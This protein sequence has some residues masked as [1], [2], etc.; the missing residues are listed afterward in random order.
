MLLGVISVL[1]IFILVPSIYASTKDVYI[2]DVVVEKK[3]GST[4]VTTNPSY[5]GMNIKLAL[6]FYGINDSIRYKVTVDNPSDED[7]IISDKGTITD[8]SNDYIKYEFGWEDTD[9]VV[10][11]NT[12]KDF[13]IDV[14][15]VKEVP[16]SGFDESGKFIEDRVITVKL[17]DE[18]NDNTDIPTVPD[19]QPSDD[20]QD[21]NE[22]NKDNQVDLVPTP[23]KTGD[24]II[25]YV[26][27]L[28]VALLGLIIL[29]I[30]ILRNRGLDLKNIFKKNINK[31]S[32][33]LFIIVVLLIVGVIGYTLGLEQVEITM[34]SRVEIEQT[35]LAMSCNADSYSEDF[36]IDW[37]KYVDYSKYPDGYT[38]SLITAKTKNM[39]DTYTNEDGVVYKL[40]NTYDV[41]DK[42]NDQVILGVY[43]ND[44]GEVLLIIG[45][46]NGVL[47]PIDSSYLFASG[48]IGRHYVES[49]SNSDFSNKMQ[50][51]NDID[52][53]KNFYEHLGNI[54]SNIMESVNYLGLENLKVDDSINM[55]GMFANN[56]YGPYKNIDYRLYTIKGL[57]NWDTSNV[58]SMNGMFAST[59]YFAT[60]IDFDLSNFDTSNVVDMGYI[61]D[62]TGKRVM[63]L[64]IGNIS[65]WDVSNV[66]SMY[67]MFNK[68]GISAGSLEMN[69]TDWN[70]SK[71]VDMGYMFY[72]C[73]FSSIGDISNWD[74]SNVK[75]MN[76]M[77]AGVDYDP[78]VF[79]LDLRNWDVS[80]VV[81]MHGMFE[82]FSG[83][84]SNIGISNWD[85][86]NVTSMDGM[87]W[88]SSMSISSI[89][90]DLSNWDVSNVVSMHG[91]FWQTGI[92]SETL[93]LNLSNWNTSKVTDMSD[94]FYLTG[95]SSKIFELNVSNWDTS[96][97]EN[98]N[99]MFY[100]TGENAL[101][102]EVDLSNWDT[103]KV[104]DMGR[105]F[106]DIGKNS[107]NP[108]LKLNNFT[109][110]NVSNFNF[111]FDDAANNLEIYVKS[112]KERDWILD[113]SSRNRPSVWSTSNILIAN[114]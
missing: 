109:F 43:Y 38:A 75:D 47:S 33:G 100:G 70:V 87:F 67:S 37:N 10:K 34:N 25:K 95:R 83:D 8:A 106:S 57:L 49:V 41:S 7:V 56:G 13:Y 97:V 52:D 24:N 104:T 46:D 19:D 64:N 5:S 53:K 42:Q 29:S 62:S 65:N 22:V 17:E 44:N 18:V 4:V 91:M 69:L 113:L 3:D 84:I 102:L 99:S 63:K 28:L 85:V 2:K 58:T 36:C 68:I 40:S 81:S 112:E 82:F 26:I 98:M 20:N 6:K 45:Q 107:Q 30:L 77:F 76:Y 9:N 35:R 89:K 14:I 71:V 96:N 73:S 80:N 59:G 114:S 11:A 74:V 39:E 105:M 86:S 61:F 48:D 50:L 32:V 55:N 72:S 15:Y 54:S 108:V 93:Q 31:Y 101:V 1:C 27:L 12:S 92:D 21:N 23:P 60:V 79:N 103:S 88:S 111:I 110:D 94:L 16:D 78:K 51:L 90:L 66:I